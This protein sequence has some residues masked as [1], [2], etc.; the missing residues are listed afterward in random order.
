MPLEERQL[1]LFCKK[2]FHW[3]DQHRH[4]FNPLQHEQENNSS[5][6]F[7]TKALGELGLLCML[8]HRSAVDS[9]EPEIEHFLRLIYE[10]WQHPEFQERI[11]RRPE[12]FQLYAMVYVVLQQCHM[13]NDSYKATIQQ[14]ID[15][16]YV[17]AT[18][19]TPMRLLDRR[20]LLD[21]GKFD[22]SLPSYEELYKHTLLA[23]EPSIVYLT[24]TD[25]YAITHTIFYLT[26]FGHRVAPELDEDHLLTVRWI[27]ETLLGLYLRRR[28]WD[29]VGELLLDCYCLH[30]YPDI[31]F[32]VAWEI[33]IE[34]QLA[35]GSMPGPRFSEEQLS[36]LRD[37]QRTLYCFEQN[38][39]STIVNAITSFLIHQ[40]L[41]HDYSENLK[42]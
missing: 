16:H 38:Y 40:D 33:L 29:L 42:R 3:I 31:V 23:H 39:H 41:Q 14:V 17:T 11:T 10:V 5:S 20:H 22:H 15:Q 7:Q 32:T 26:D 27:I 13:I 9:Q 25:V 21:C 18:E 8:Y 37:H 24:D 19:T 30:W 2:A 4:L 1:H 36:G 35:D 6:L 28:H 34:A 12:Y